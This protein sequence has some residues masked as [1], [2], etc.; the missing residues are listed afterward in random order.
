MKKIFAF[1]LVCALTLATFTACNSGSSSSDASSQGTSS[2]AGVSS[3][4][5]SSEAVKDVSLT[6]IH[7]AVK[8]AYGDNYGASMEYP[9]D[10]LEEQF[11]LKKD[12]YDEVIAEGPMMSAHVDTFIAVKAAEG[13][14][15]AV[16]KALND[17]RETQISGAMQ[18][19]M[20]MPKIQASR[21]IRKGDYVFFL[22]LGYISSEEEE[23]DE[24][25]QVEAFQKQNDIGEKAITD[26]LG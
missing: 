3:Q 26:L 5:A 10:I 7:D 1:V 6:E 13:K 21:V 14:A 18:Y 16:E 4:E 23:L 17:Y 25:K 8:K 22:M 9:S 2:S 12:M 15:E 20:N 11:G 19:P 24:E